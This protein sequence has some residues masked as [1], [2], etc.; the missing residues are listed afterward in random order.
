MAALGQ[1]KHENDVSAE[2]ESV[3]SQVGLLMQ[4]CNPHTAELEEEEEE[5][6][7]S[8]SSLCYVARPCLK[9]QKKSNQTGCM[10][11]ADEKGF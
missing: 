8:G 9:I 11:R 1:N 5:E 6:G 7:K 4:A 10:K 2:T 3:S